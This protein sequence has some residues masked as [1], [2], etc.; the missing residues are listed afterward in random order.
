MS[1]DCGAA[2]IG[3]SSDERVGLHLFLASVVESDAGSKHD[4]DAFAG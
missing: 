3:G 4:G 1:A 2:G